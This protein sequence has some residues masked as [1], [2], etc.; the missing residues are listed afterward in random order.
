MISKF[1]VLHKLFRQPTYMKQNIIG[2]SW[3]GVLWSF[4]VMVSVLYEESYEYLEE[5]LN[6]GE[7]EFFESIRFN[8]APKDH[9]GDSLQ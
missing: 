8:K 2:N 5:S 9:W 6:S 4:R 7:K 3:E 1:V